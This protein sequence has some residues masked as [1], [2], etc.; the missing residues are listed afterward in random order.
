[1]KALVAYDSAYGNTAK[2]ATAIGDVLASA[3]SADVKLAESIDGKD[4]KGYSLVA[5][6]CPTQ[7]GAS[8]EAYRRI[9]C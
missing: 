5:V 2:V 6:G 8:Y 7:G 9:Y 4:I 3:G 1:M